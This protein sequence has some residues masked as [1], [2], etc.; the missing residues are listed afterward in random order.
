MTYQ[1]IPFLWV[2]TLIATLPRF[3]EC[4]QKYPMLFPCLLVSSPPN[5]ILQ[6]LFS[7]VL[8]KLMEL[9]TMERTQ[10]SALLLQK[11]QMAKKITLMGQFSE[12]SSFRFLFDNTTLYVHFS[13]NRPNFQCVIHLSS[14][15]L[16][17]L[18]VV[19]S[20]LE[21]VRL[22]KEML[23]VLSPI[24]LCNKDSCWGTISNYTRGGSTWLASCSA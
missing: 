14:L 17:Y 12:C 6:T 4:C 22:A 13:N 1:N 11:Y 20:F 8:L 16:F 5:L 18:E 10:T 24:L 3:M 2:A 23:I 19:F 7:I 9:F 21:L 15:L